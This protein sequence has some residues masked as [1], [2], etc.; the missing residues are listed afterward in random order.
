MKW[1]F[2]WTIWSNSLMLDKK[3]L[4]FFIVF[5]W[6]ALITYF[7]YLF[8]LMR[9]DVLNA[10]KW[11]SWLWKQEIKLKCLWCVEKKFAVKC[12]KTFRNQNFLFFCQ[13]N[14]LKNDMLIKQHYRY[15]IFLIKFNYLIGPNILQLV[16]DFITY[17]IICR[18]DFL[19]TCWC[20]PS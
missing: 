4:H 13:F 2:R 18:L 12:I 8:W 11:E 19:R 6:N 1:S 5:I 20:E 3:I 7:A 16:L 17:S 14:F 10:I 9:H 15:L